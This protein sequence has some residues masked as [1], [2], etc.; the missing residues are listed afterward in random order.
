MHYIVLPV[1]F[2]GRLSIL[3]LRK[4]Q[5]FTK[6]LDTISKKCPFSKPGEVSKIKNGNL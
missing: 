6:K 5:F 3:D 1:K 2:D 4:K